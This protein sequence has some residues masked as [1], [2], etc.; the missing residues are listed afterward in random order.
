M[1]TPVATLCNSGDSVRIVPLA[2]LASGDIVQLP[3]GRAAVYESARSADTGDVNAGARVVARWAVKKTAS[4]VFLHGS[5]VYYDRA[6]GLATI[7]KGV[8]RFWIGTVAKD[9][10]AADATVDVFLNKRACYVTELGGPWEEGGGFAASDALGLGSVFA[11][12]LVTLAFDAVAEIARASILAN[13]GVDIDDGPIAEF[14]LAVFNIGD[15]AALDIN[16]GLAT[17][18]HATDFDASAQY[19]AVHLDGN[20]LVINTQSK[21]GTNNVAAQTASVSVVDD[22]YYLWQFDCRDKSNIKI[23]RN[24]VLLAGAATLHLNAYTG[25]LYLVVHLEKTSDDTVAEVR[26]RLARVRTSDVV[27]AA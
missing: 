6:T 16:F 9:A 20:S 13:M 2:A 26:V 14:E 12:N 1:A 22:T 19:V 4:M 24:G 15:N 23:Y 17:E 3:D 21:D 25:T 11:D 10:A 5:N 7:L 8:G 18:A 27:I